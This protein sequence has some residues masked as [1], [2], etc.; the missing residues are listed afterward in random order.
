VDGVD[1]LRV[2]EERFCVGARESVEELHL[3]VAAATEEVG[4]AGAKAEPGH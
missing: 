2:S 4:A 3:A 1:L